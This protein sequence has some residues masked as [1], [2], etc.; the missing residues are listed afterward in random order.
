MEK[1]NYD[2]FGF[3]LWNDIQ[4]DNRYEMLDEK[5]AKK[6]DNFQK[7]TCKYSDII[8]QLD[9]TLIPKIIRETVVEVFQ[10][11]TNEENTS[12]VIF[13]VIDKR[14]KPQKPRSFN[15]VNYLKEQI[16]F[17]DVISR[18]LG[19][20]IE[21]TEISGIGA[22]VRFQKVDPNEPPFISSN[23]KE[24]AKFWD[25]CLQ[26]VSDLHE[27]QFVVKENDNLLKEAKEIEEELIKHIKKSMEK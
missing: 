27:L 2:R 22:E 17:S 20:N 19:T 18:A 14:T 5:L 1:K 13:H 11:E 23:F 16:Q 15:V 12:P 25:M 4:N 3:P 6:L 26:K 9:Y 21:K 24:I 8:S 7:S 10:E